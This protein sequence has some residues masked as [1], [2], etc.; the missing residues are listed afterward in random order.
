MDQTPISNLQSL[1]SNVLLCGL[2][3]S[4]CT[5]PHSTRPVIKIGLLAPF[6][7]LGRPLGY[8]VLYGVKL[9]LRERNEAGGVAGYQ[10]ALVALNDNDDASHAARQARKLAVDGDVLG[11]IGPFSRATARAVADPLSEAGLAWLVPASAPDEVIAAHSN[12]FRLFAS[13]VALAEAAI[14]QA[15]SAEVPGAARRVAVSSRGD[16]AAPL[17]AA[18]QRLGVYRPLEEPLEGEGFAVALGGNGEQVAEEL[19]CLSGWRRL[20]AGGH[21]RRLPAGLDSPARA[22]CELLSLAS[23]HGAVM[24]AGPEAGRAVVAQRAGEAAEGLIWVSSVPPADAGALPPTFVSGYQTLAGSPP[25]P[26]S[27]LAYDATNVLLEAIAFDI[28]RNA[29]PTRQGVIAALPATQTTGLSGRIRFDEQ[30]TWLQAPIFVYRV[31]G[32][33]LFT[34]P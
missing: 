10:V 17:R 32:D 15:V 26:Y 22:N 5:L 21:V 3:L 24:I 31:V 20:A 12:A 25:R 16:F 2:L 13:D 9:A 8:E 1:I 34:R 29:R 7:G 11:V 27:I 6:E 4:A 30:G 28:A 19:L 23:D 14:E 33:D 18:A